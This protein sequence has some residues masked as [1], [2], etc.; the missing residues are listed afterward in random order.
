MHRMVAQPK[1]VLSIPGH[2]GATT[3][4]V[5]DVSLLFNR[6]L[7]SAEAFLFKSGVPMQEHEQNMQES[8]PRG[9]GLD[10]ANLENT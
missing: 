2:R 6:F 1:A 10:T 3:L 8:Q 7:C 9:A 4:H 5:L